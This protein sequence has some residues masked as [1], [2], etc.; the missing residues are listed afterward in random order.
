[1][2][3]QGE[4]SRYRRLPYK[5]RLDKETD[6]EGTYFVCRYPELPGLFAD[7]KTRSEAIRNADEA[8]DDYILARLSFEDP[9]PKPEGAQR[10][11]RALEFADQAPKGALTLEIVLEEVKI[12]LSRE[13][14]KRTAKAMIRGEE[15]VPTRSEGEKRIYQERFATA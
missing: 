4:L 8:F 11:S 5:R 7:G 10:V 2:S 15:P 1:M 3:P 14:R 13:A 12:S 6:E 9:I